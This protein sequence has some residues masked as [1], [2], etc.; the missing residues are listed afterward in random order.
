[1]RRVPKFESL[2]ATPHSDGKK[3]RLGPGFGKES[4]RLEC[5]MP[6]R[7]TEIKGIGPLESGMKELSCDFSKMRGWQTVC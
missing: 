4:H 7:V 2:I 6:N 5:M 1:M 3:K